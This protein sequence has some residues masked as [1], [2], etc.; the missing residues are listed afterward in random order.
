M[1]KAYSYNEMVMNVRQKFDLEDQSVNVGLETAA[2]DVC[3]GCKVEIDEEV[4]PLMRMSLDEVT[5][6]VSGGDSTAGEQGPALASGLCAPIRETSE[7]AAE[8]WQPMEDEGQRTMDVQTST[9]ALGKKLPTDFG[10]RLNTF[11]EGNEDATSEASLPR[12]NDSEEEFNDEC[13]EENEEEPI[14]PSAITPTRRHTVRFATEEP[15]PTRDV[16]L[17]QPNTTQDLEARFQVRITA[18][19]DQNAEIKTRGK[20]LV[21]KV[22]AAICKT[23]N[24]DYDRA[25]LYLITRDET[26]DSQTGVHYVRCPPDWSMARCGIT[27]MSELRVQ[28]E[29]LPESAALV[30]QK[31]K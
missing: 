13:R 22:L 17:E 23:F 7:E 12:K 8:G 5:V 1:L 28:L 25:A 9:P 27:S 4:W 15:Q 26:T 6:V 16:R 29:P 2:L 10:W 3:R 24:L 21:K 18:H 14:T 20:H 31:S 11:L 19:P 30:T